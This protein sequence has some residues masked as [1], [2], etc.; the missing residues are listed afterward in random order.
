MATAPLT[1][2]ILDVGLTMLSNGG[3]KK[4]A[5]LSIA[6]AALESF[7]RVPG[8]GRVALLLAGV[9]SSHNALNKAGV[10]DVHHIPADELERDGLTAPPYF[11]P[12]S[13]DDVLHLTPDALDDSLSGPTDLWVALGVAMSDV[14]AAAAAGHLPPSPEAG[15]VRFLIISDF[16]TGVPAK[17]IT[18]AAAVAAVMCEFG[19]VLDICVV[20]SSVELDALERE[21]AFRAGADDVPPVPPS[22][23]ASALFGLSEAAELGWEE[24]QEQLEDPGAPVG[25][26][27]EETGVGAGV[28]AGAG[29]G[30]GL[31]GGRSSSVPHSRPAARKLKLLERLLRG[32]GDTEAVGVVDSRADTGSCPATVLLQALTAAAPA[33]LGRALTA[34]SALAMLAVPAAP[35]KAVKVA[36]ELRFGGDGD[37]GAVIHGSLFGVVVKTAPKFK[38]ITEAAYLSEWKQREAAVTERGGADSEAGGDEKMGGHADE[39]GVGAGAGVG[40]GEGRG[41]KRGRVSHTGGA[42][43]TG[44][45]T[46]SMYYIVPLPGQS[47]AAAVARAVGGVDADIDGYRAGLAGGTAANADAAALNG[48]A[49]YDAGEDVGVIGNAAGGGNDALTAADKVALTIDPSRVVKGFRYGTSTIPIPPSHPAAESMIARSTEDRGMRALGFVPMASVPR[50]AFAGPPRWFMPSAEKKRG[51]PA[52]SSGPLCALALAMHE[53]GVGLLCRVVARKGSNPFFAVAIP[54]LDATE[55]AAEVARA[56]V[57]T[58]AAAAAAEEPG[59][60]EVEGAAARGGAARPPLGPVVHEGVLGGLHPHAPLVSPVPGTRA[61]AILP[62]PWADDVREYIRVQPPFTATV[63]GLAAAIAAEA[64]AEAAETARVDKLMHAQLAGMDADAAVHALSPPSPS[65]PPQPRVSA[66]IAAYTQLVG[67]MG[68]F[69]DALDLGAD[70]GWRPERVPNPYLLRVD[71]FLSRRVRDP[72]AAV[73]PPCEALS[74][75]ALSWVDPLEIAKRSA[76][77]PVAV[78]SLRKA[79]QAAG[80]LT[81]LHLVRRQAPAGV[82]WPAACGR[83]R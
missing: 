81:L 82:A 18:K 33:V 15:A 40:V 69:V 7:L 9:T 83:G 2:V 79:I 65:P 35:P 30:A 68:D 39:A 71:D 37:E 29:A 26:Q 36:I 41:R 62:L 21:T 77:H 74:A 64:A 53:R 8:S 48:A 31:G 5:A 43:H 13:A 59:V 52:N 25:A 46:D 50:Y 57:S 73:P 16:E 32:D 61:L 19:I 12:P 6:R 27:G 34:R 60:L 51:S 24:A 38:H 28:G 11:A 44:F 42:A 63:D 3:R 45:T 20:R 23:D 55:L 78:K 1:C 10:H 67:A 17:A 4:A 66:K 22:T 54:A 72:E 56:Q 58:A 76:T 80:G 47:I 49:R 75:A 70:G 14:E